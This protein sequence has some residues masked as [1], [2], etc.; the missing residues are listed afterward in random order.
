M[1][2]QIYNAGIY[3]RISK[4]DEQGGF[5]VSI[6]NQKSL[7]T[8]YVLERGWNLV[9]CYIDHGYSGLNFQRPGVQRMI[10][11]AASGRINVILVKDLSRFS[12]NYIEFGQYT[13]YFFPSIGCRFVAVNNGVDTENEDGSLAFMSMMNLFN[14]HYSL[15][16]SRKVRAVRRSNAECGRFMGAHPPYGYLRDPADKHRFVI[17]GETA[18]IIRMIFS[19]RASGEGYR[20]IAILLNEQHIYSPGVLYYMRQG[21]RDP[22]GTNGQWAAA[23]VKSI[24]ENEAYIGNMVQGKYGSPSCKIKKTAAKPR[25]EWIRVEGTHEAIIPIELWNAVRALDGSAPRARETSDGIRSMFSGLV[26]CA[27]CGFRMRNAVERFTYK[28]GRPGRY[29]SFLC[30]N[31]SRSGKTACTTHTINEKDLYEIVRQNL[32]CRAEKSCL[33]SA[34]VQGEADVLKHEEVRNAIAACEAELC[35]AEARARKVELLMKS[36]HEDKASGIISESVFSLLMGRYRE[37]YTQK[38]ELISQ[39]S[40]RLAAL[41]ETLDLDGDDSKQLERYLEIT[42]LDEPLLRAL[43]QRI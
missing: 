38:T 25:E 24:L 26:Y 43:V 41:R 12:R 39:L 36:L 34:C 14:E 20:H 17:D 10:E 21:R 4:D 37:E 31:Y 19:L 3:C 6:E 42:E 2:E 29:S 22:R 18:P 23:T 7:L 35:D 30:G 16:L 40:G 8:Q 27:D 9:D 15:D 5:S 33:D 1:T 13:H 11:D 28:D 32:R